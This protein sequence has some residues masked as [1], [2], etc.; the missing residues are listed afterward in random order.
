MAHPHR[1][2]YR[3]IMMLW[4]LERR[5]RMC[6][7]VCDF[8]PPSVRSH[9]SKLFFFSDLQM[10]NSLLICLS[11][12]FSPARIPNS[13][14][15]ASF[16]KTGELSLMRSTLLISF[17]C[18]IT[19]RKFP[20]RGNFH[21]SYEWK[22]NQMNKVRKSSSWPVQGSGGSVYRVAAFYPTHL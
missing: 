7:A 4:H 21:S 12:F 6:S 8:N 20:V 17:N 22:L 1:D 16:L 5:L 9:L 10:C 14:W 13:S 18:F 3:M 19:G 15:L 2:R 11:F